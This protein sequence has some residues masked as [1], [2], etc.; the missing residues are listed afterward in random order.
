[1]K[2]LASDRTRGRPANHMTKKTSNTSEV[3]AEQVTNTPFDH[4]YLGIDLHKKSISVARIIDGATPEATRQFSWAKFWEF[5]AKQKALA[6]TVHAVYEAG[7]FG[8]WPCRQLQQMGMECWVIHPEKLDPRRRRVQNDRLDALNLGLKLQRY[9]G[10]NQKA[11]TVVY[12]PSAAEEQERLVARERDHLS[13][14]IGALRARGRGL[15]LS[16]GIFETSGWY[17]A[18]VWEKLQP[19]LSAALTRV[20]A[21]LRLSMEHLVEQLATVEK[22][23]S[24]AA[25]AQLPKGFGKL[26]FVLLQRLLCNYR[27]FGNRR[28]AAGFTGLCGGVSASGDYHLDLSINKAGSPRIRTLL[29]ELA[30]RMIYYQPNYRGLATWKRLGGAQAAK[31][32]RKIALVATARQ[33]MVDLWRWQ[34]GRNTPEQLGWVM[35]QS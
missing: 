20:L 16:Q 24:A 34:T 25:P 17:R 18:G 28:Q 14:Q 29:I 32:R 22:E 9:V 10:G 23:L 19:R 33:L 1:M 27:R 21:D 31:R 2:R 12:V 3:R 15:L 5:V 11:M 30:W 4:I 7:A 6:R 8:F 26:T 13:Q 35:S